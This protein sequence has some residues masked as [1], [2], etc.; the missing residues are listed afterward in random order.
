MIDYMKLS[1]SQ[2]SVLLALINLIVC[3]VILYLNTFLSSLYLGIV[4]G[5][6]FIGLTGLL[7]Y[8]N[9]SYH[10][11]KKKTKIR[12]IVKGIIKKK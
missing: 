9:R 2:A 11:R 6:I 3:V 8:V 12:H 1:H 4:L 7:F 5:V 10:I